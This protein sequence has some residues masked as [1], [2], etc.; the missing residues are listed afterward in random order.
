MSVI[1]RSAHPAALWPGVKAMFGQAYNEVSPEWSS[2]F[3]KGTS[4]KAYEKL[5]EITGFGLAPAKPEGESISYDEDGEGYTNVLTHIVY[6]LGYQVTREENEDN[7]YEEVSM[8]RSPALAYSMR[9]TAEITHANILNRSQSGSYTYG[10][11]VALVS[12][13][14]P[15]LAGNQSNLL[16]AADLSEASVEDGL[17]AIRQATNARGLKVAIKAKRL[18]IHTDD[19]FNATRIFQS[20]QRVSTANNDINAMKVLGSIP[21]IVPMTFLT[22]NDGWFIQTDVPQG[23]AS[24]WRREVELTKDKDFDTENAKAKATMRFAAGFGDWRCLYGNA[25]S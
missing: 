3:K 21:E 25:G 6:G 14:H 24:L 17:K 4:D 23:L 18:I 11:G 13:A 19:I 20:D 15:T 5:V 7:L 9:Q 12:N 16:T 1:T 8:R 2:V 10:D 22:D